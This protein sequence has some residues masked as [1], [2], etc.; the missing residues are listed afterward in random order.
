MLMAVTTAK[1]S[2]IIDAHPDL[3]VTNIDLQLVGVSIKVVG[4][5]GKTIVSFGV[6]EGER[7]AISGKV[8]FADIEPVDLASL[9]MGQN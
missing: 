2:L 8:S 1:K 4:P 3:D 6:K 9:P 5:E 7:K